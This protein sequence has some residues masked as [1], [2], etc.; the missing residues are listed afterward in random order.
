MKCDVLPLGI[1]VGSTRIRVVES[2]RNGSRTQIRAVAVRDVPS[3]TRTCGP[4]SEPAY[5]A[6]LIEDALSEIGSRQRRCVC[7][8]GEPDAI[9]RLI[10]LPNMTV[11]ERERAARFEA[12]RFIEY[13]VEEA[14]IRIHPMDRAAGTWALGITRASSILTRIAALRAAGIKPIAMDHEA[15]AL[16]RSLPGFDAILDIGH[17]RTSLHVVRPRETPA[18]LQIYNG[19]ADVTRGIER[20]LSLDNQTAEKR[21]RILG[22][23]GAGERARAVLIADI[24]ALIGTART[25]HEIAR[26]ALVGNAARLPGLAQD[27]QSATGAQCEIPV[28][29]S[30]RTEAYPHDV[31]RSS[32]P[33]WTLAASLSHW[34][35]N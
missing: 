13:P 15:C 28:S 31:I 9:L 8:V 23:A 16:A 26:I 21:K 35:V 17:Q 3:G 19:G 27:L 32:A 4:V 29:E 18:T 12:Q 30:L 14:V 2:E 34:S 7:A 20:D 22:T 24:A 33:D 1:D 6:A 5:I 11:F 25:A 10:R